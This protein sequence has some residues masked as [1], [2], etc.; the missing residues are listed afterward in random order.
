MTQEGDMPQ[1]E[2]STTE[3]KGEM[4]WEGGYMTLESEVTQ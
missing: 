3:D 1:D 2:C 4:T